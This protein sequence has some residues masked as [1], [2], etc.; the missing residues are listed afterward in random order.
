MLILWHIWLGYTNQLTDILI[1]ING[2]LKSCLNFFLKSLYMR[3]NKKDYWL[4][5]EGP[6]FE[7]P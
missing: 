5:K 4:S 2:G 7:V 1:K 3:S 6:T